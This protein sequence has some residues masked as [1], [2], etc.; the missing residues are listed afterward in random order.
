AAVGAL[1]LLLALSYWRPLRRVRGALGVSHLVA[2]G[3]VF[4]VLGWLLGLVLGIDED[5]RL[6]SELGP[7]VA[8]AAGWVG[9]AAGTRFEDR[10][11]AAVPIRGFATA[12][13]PGVVAA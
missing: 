5:R 6:A 4:L 10:V 8:F 7:L 12:L 9:F 2:T 3:H 13:V 1:I 11:L